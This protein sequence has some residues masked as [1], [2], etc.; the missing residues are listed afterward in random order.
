MQPVSRAFCSSLLLG[1]LLA[2]FSALAPA[3]QVPLKRVVELALSH[4]TATA[5][6]D[7]AAQRAYASYRETRNQYLPSLVVGSGLGKTWGYP[8]S[9][10]GSAPAIINATAQS[11]VI[12]P[13]LREFVREARTEWEVSEVSR[14]DQREQVIEDTVLSYTELNKW[15]SLLA[16]LSEEYSTALKM[17]Q[18]VNQRIQAGVDN[19]QARTQARL[20]AA[21]VYLHM[22]QAQGSIDVLRSQLSHWTGL[23]AAS[24]ETDPESIPSLP[25]VKQET[26]LVARAATVSPA[27]QIASLQATALQFHARGEHRS[28]WPSVDFASQYALLAEFNN[29]QNFFKSGSFQHNNASIGT[30]IR[31]PFFSPSQR[32]RARAADAEALRARQDLEATKDHVSEQTLKLERSVE[33]LAAAR[34]VADLQYQVAKSNL[35]AIEIKVDSGTAT[36]HDEDDAR[37]L[38]SEQYNTLEDTAFELERAQITLLRATG[39]LSSWVGAGK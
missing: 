12:N 29:Y 24:I 14:K 35:E 36:L 27:I 8:L 28:M 31:F 19:P 9:L 10:E 2:P 4:G 17:E 25:P 37:N 16:H 22:T 13:A 15:E 38:A 33:Q 26:D 21:R 3:E 34:E 30:V 32:A 39:E 1:I 7:A 6:A 18:L 11:A 23:P 20:N 5:A